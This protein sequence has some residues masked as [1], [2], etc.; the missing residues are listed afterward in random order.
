MRAIHAHVVLI[1]GCILLASV[2]A[3]SAQGAS[4]LGLP[5]TGTGVDRTMAQTP[6]NESDDYF[7]VTPDSVLARVRTTN[8]IELR[9]TNFDSEVHDFSIFIITTCSYL[10]LYFSGSKLPR[11]EITGG[12]YVFVVPADLDYFVPNKT[13]VIA[14]GLYPDLPEGLV[15]AL[16][17]LQFNLSIDGSVCDVERVSVYVTESY[18]MI[19]NYPLV[20]E[21][22]ISPSVMFKV[23]KN[24]LL[25]ASGTSLTLI[26]NNT[27]S[28]PH[29][30]TLHINDR[31][32]TLRIFE[33]INEL[34]PG[35]NTTGHEFTIPLGG[36]FVYQE[37]PLIL[38]AEQLPGTVWFRQVVE[39][40]VTVDSSQFQPCYFGLDVGNTEALN[41]T[42]DDIV[43]EEV[44]SGA[45]RGTTHVHGLPQAVLASLHLALMLPDVDAMPLFRVHDDGELTVVISR[46]TLGLAADRLLSG[47][48]SVCIAGFYGRVGL[49]SIVHGLVSTSSP[50]IPLLLYV[51]I[52]AGAC[53]VVILAAI[54]YR[55]RY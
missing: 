5:H 4:V 48:S 36:N 41:V 1:A 14:V 34:S 38:L 42:F 28:M 54:W 20:K 8:T 10:D 51:G 46:D 33:G 55:R 23:E 47:N 31:A 24:P 35:V 29:E 39:L 52:G 15:Y 45:V 40:S 19:E 11:H 17:E 25:A 32:G 53:V 50:A 43:F 27:D 2:V 6:D 30:Y 9:V 49:A 3:P 18:E 44:E 21:A 37:V 7:V 13:V 22:S 12:K 16:T 26:V